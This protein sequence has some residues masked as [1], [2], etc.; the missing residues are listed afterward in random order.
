MKKPTGEYNDDEAAKRAEDTIRRML[1][2]PHKPI[3]CRN[4]AARQ[5]HNAGARR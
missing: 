1:T 4:E 3:C 2:T 5:I